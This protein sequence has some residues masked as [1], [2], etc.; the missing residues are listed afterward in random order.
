LNFWRRFIAQGV[1]GFYFRKSLARKIGCLT[2][3]SGRGGIVWISDCNRCFDGYKKDS[4]K[5]TVT[6]AGDDFYESDVTNDSYAEDDNLLDSEDDEIS[7]D[8]CDD[9]SVLCFDHSE[10]HQ[11][12]MIGN[13]LVELPFLS[14]SLHTVTTC[15]QCVDTDLLSYV[16]FC[17]QQT[18]TLCVA[19]DE[20]KTYKEKYM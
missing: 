3:P 14:S 8:S 18:K 11:P 12:L 13:H 6:P 15:K 10:S 19:A 16:N 4:N 2:Y 20:K 1:V 9:D 17:V 5:T 7:L